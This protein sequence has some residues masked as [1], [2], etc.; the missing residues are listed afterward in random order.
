LIINYKL[1]HVVSRRLK[2][3][4]RKSKNKCKYIF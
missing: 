3:F 2:E 1:H 4:P